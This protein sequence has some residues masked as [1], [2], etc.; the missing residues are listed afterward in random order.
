MVEAT[1][2]PALGKATVLSVRLAR[3]PADGED[4]ASKGSLRPELERLLEKTDR[5]VLGRGE[6]GT[7]GFDEAS[8]QRGHR[9]RDGCPGAGQP[10]PAGRTY[11]HRG[12]PLVTTPP[13]CQNAASGRSLPG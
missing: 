2:S 1:G 10:G 5:L 3:D 9:W 6:V 4:V 11:R 7:S 13:V 12:P 8:Q